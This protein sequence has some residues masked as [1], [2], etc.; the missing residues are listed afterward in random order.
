M[1]E[2]EIETVAPSAAGLFKAMGK[3]RKERVIALPGLDG[4]APTDQG[5][6]PRKEHD[7]Y[8]TPPEPTW[9]LCA[10]EGDELRRFSRLWEPAIGDGSMARELVA[11]G[12]DVV[13]SDL[14][15]R[16]IGATIADYFVVRAPMARAAVTNPPFSLSA[17]RA[18]YA[19][20][21]H[22]WETLRLDYMALLLPIS[23]MGSDKLAR[24]WHRMPPVRIY[25]MTWRIDFTG[26]KGQPV[27]H[28]WYVWDRAAPRAEPTLHR[29]KRPDAPPIVP[30]RL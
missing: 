29:M 13:G 17:S 12:H 5:E 30:W 10:A 18:R 27:Y 3:R 14:I 26:E 11:C 22:G 21:V 16:G 19:W 6:A 28:A 1:A 25:V 20:A 23:W 15:D 2:V 4:V 24:V 7:F 9:A 8:A